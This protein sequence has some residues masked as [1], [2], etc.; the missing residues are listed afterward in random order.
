MRRV[1]MMWFCANLIAGM[2]AGGEAGIEGWKNYR[3]AKFGYE[4]FYPAEMEYVSYIEGGS[5]DLKDARTG[6]VLAEFE[7]WPPDMCPSQAADTQAKEIGIRRAKD[8]TQ[9]DGHGSSSYCGEPMTVREIASPGSNKIY[10][11]ELTCISDIYPGPGDDE[12]DAVQEAPIVEAEPIITKEGKKGPTY[13]VDISQSW[14]KRVL[15]V[16]PTGVDPRRG[17]KDQT[18]VPVLRKILT[19]L[20]TFPVEKPPGICIEDLSR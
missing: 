18:V 2:A 12:V 9:A 14:R 4:L 5:G 11:L 7:V 1:W 8:A 17:D 13:F 3:N 19:T 15:M 6:S 10:E 16:D 20:R